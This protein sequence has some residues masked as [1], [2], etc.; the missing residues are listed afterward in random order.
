MEIVTK[1]FLN[2]RM[3]D[4]MGELN[5]ADEMN[6]ESVSSIQETLNIMKEYLG[7]QKISRPILPGINGFFINDNDKLFLMLQKDGSVAVKRLTGDNSNPITTLSPNDVLD[8]YG[9]NKFRLFICD[10][11]EKLTKHYRKINDDDKNL[12]ISTRD[13]KRKAEELSDAVK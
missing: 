11:A 3:K 9:S 5:K 12:H 4:L 7:H 10:T 13:M 1:P 6:D 8:K 2:G